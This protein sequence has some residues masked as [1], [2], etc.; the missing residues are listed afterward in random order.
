[1]VWSIGLILLGGIIVDYPYYLFCDILCFNNYPGSI[2]YEGLYLIFGPFSPCSKMDR[3][4]I[5]RKTFAAAAVAVGQRQCHQNHR[6]H[7]NHRNGP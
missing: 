7:H 5:T 4:A 1:M 6:R 3:Q 2:D